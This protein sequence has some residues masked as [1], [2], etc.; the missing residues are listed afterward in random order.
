MIRYLLSMIEA[1]MDK[2]RI[3][4]LDNSTDFEL[5]ESDY[6][7][8]HEIPNDILFSQ[9]FVEWL[10]SCDSRQKAYPIFCD[11]M[12]LPQFR[13]YKDKKID[14][15][16]VEILFTWPSVTT[17]QLFVTL[18][19]LNG[20]NSI[21]SWDIEKNMKSNIDFSIFEPDALQIFLDED[22]KE[23]TDF[24]NKQKDISSYIIAKLDGGKE[25]TED[26]IYYVIENDTI[27]IWEYSDRSKQ[28]WYSLGES[29]GKRGI[30]KY[31]EDI[32]I[33][34]LDLDIPASYLY[35]VDTT[36]ELCELLDIHNDQQLTREAKREDRKDRISF[37]DAKQL[38][39]DKNLSDKIKLS[40]GSVG[41]EDMSFDY[42]IYNDEPYGTDG[43]FA[44]KVWV[45]GREFGDNKIRK[46]TLINLI[47]LL[48]GYK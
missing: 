5:S 37:E 47:E 15:K 28:F 22:D 7:F 12:E 44:G 24:I 25:L 33:S 42:I 20:K 31:F 26:E 13:Y 17:K 4:D 34:N 1:G 10:I 27:H 3:Y 9:D 41:L 32:D 39:K 43:I 2:E 29:N 11:Y 23:I 35:D 30:A 36:E 45:N 18:A 16:I 8:F 38:I 46:S 19:N 48:G 6:R 21:E 14:A 40:P